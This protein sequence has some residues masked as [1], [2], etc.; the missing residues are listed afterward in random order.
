MNDS[1]LKAAAKY[2]G[3]EDWV[4]DWQTAEMTQLKYDEESADD[5]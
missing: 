3:V 1:G 4:S 5:H 2:E